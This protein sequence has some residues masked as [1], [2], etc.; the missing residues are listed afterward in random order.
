MAKRQRL[1]PPGQEGIRAQVDR[2]SSHFARAQ[3]AP[4]ARIGLEQHHACAFRQ[5]GGEL[6]SRGESGDA[7]T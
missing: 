5:R 6:P 4:E 7:T 2:P 3:L 1:L